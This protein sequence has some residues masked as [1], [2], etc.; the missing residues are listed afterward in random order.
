MAELLDICFVLNTRIFNWAFVGL[1]GK[2]TK[3]AAKARNEGPSK[4]PD[5]LCESASAPRTAATRNRAG[6]P[7]VPRESKALMGCTLRT[8]ETRAPIQQSSQ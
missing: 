6:F 3:T 4:A 5:P 1:L 2:S 7:P 8:P